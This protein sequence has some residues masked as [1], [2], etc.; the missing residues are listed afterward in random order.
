MEEEIRADR[1]VLGEPDEVVSRTTVR[2]GSGGRTLSVSLAILLLMVATPFL[3]TLIGAVTA[4][5]RIAHIPV[6]HLLFLTGDSPSEHTTTLRG[7]FIVDPSGQMRQIAHDA[8]AE[9]EDTGSRTWI[10]E[11]SVSPDGKWVAYLQQT[12]I[13]LDEK[14]SMAEGLYVYNLASDSALPVREYDVLRSDQAR[15]G[16]V[17]LTWTPDSRLIGYVQDSTLN[18]FDPTRWPYPPVKLHHLPALQ[19]DR[20]ISAL[21]YPKFS[22]NGALTMIARTP[23]GPKLIG[24]VQPLSLPKDVSTE[25]IRLAGET[26]WPLDVP[27]AGAYGLS[28]DGT[29]AALAPAGRSHEIAMV[30]TRNG[31]LKRTVTAKWGWSVFGGRQIT[32][33]G[34]S[35]DG[36]FLAYTVSKPPVPE[37]ELFVMTLATGEIHLLP[38]RTGRAGWTWVK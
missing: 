36:R 31:R 35:P 20:Y 30:D 7:L 33:V 11:P 9:D 19:T 18:L 1:T 22:P 12:I 28:P 27:M 21:S 25:S 34:Y 37:E 32:S 17:G 2:K 23:S 10:D 13:L 5:S 26:T 3:F 15:K 38:Y 29:E 24:S 16:M 14:Q 8:E 4:P 6:G